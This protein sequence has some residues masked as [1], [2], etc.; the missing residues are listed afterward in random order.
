MVGSA[1]P[2]AAWSWIVDAG[3]CAAKRHSGRA[4]GRFGACRSCAAR[5]AQAVVGV[6]ESAIYTGTRASR[7]TRAA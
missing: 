2:A 3:R 4:T 5:H 1:V 6:V 7:P